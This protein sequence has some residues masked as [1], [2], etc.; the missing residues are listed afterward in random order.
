MGWLGDVFGEAR[1]PSWEEVLGYV[2]RHFFRWVSVKMS[3][4]GWV[5]RLSWVRC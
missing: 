2:S 1:V 3:T 4:I 5:S